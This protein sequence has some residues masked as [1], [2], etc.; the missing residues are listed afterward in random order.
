MAEFP[1]AGLCVVHVIS[2]LFL[3]IFNVRFSLRRGRGRLSRLRHDLSSTE[4]LCHRS[5]QGYFALW[6]GSRATS[7]WGGIAEPL[8]WPWAQLWVSIATPLGSEGCVE[9]CVPVPTPGL[10]CPGSWGVLALLTSPWFLAEVESDILRRVRALLR[11]LDGHHP[12]CQ[13]DRGEG[14]G[15]ARAPLTLPGLR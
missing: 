3:S 12:S 5:L 7:P 2:I 9:G 11:E 1:C 6:F 15:T 10:A 4:L 14:A 8:Q 13:S